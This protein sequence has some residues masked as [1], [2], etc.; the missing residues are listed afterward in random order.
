M[1]QADDYYDYTRDLKMQEQKITIEV[2]IKPTRL[3]RIKVN[4]TP[5]PEER[6]LEI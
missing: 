2:E 4:I 6:Y 3:K 1:I 5:K